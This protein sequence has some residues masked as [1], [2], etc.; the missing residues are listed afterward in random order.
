[1]I[2]DGRNPFF[3]KELE[4]GYVVLGDF[5]FFRGYTLFLC[6]EHVAELHLLSPRFKKRYLEEMSLVAEAVWNWVNPE[7][8]NYEA[9]GNAIPHLHWHIFPRHKDDPLPKKPIWEIPKEQRMGKACM[10][11]ESVLAE[12]CDQLKAHIERLIV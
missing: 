1:M 8:L 9:L 3:V 5:Q 10:P 7:V 11:D 2:R 4:T 6:K 12:Y